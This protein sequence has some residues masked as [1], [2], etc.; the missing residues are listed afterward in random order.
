MPVHAAYVP[1]GGEQDYTNSSIDWGF[2]S[3]QRVESGESTYQLLRAG[4]CSG[5]SQDGL[6]R[7][8]P[9]KASNSSKVT[10]DV[11]AAP[12]NNLLNSSSLMEDLVSV[13]V[14][15]LVW[16]SPTLPPVL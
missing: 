16:S 5:D 7:T 15:I 14:D 11:E 6:P 8:V 13:G 9:C 3:P 2:S 4:V 10:A 1:E 12:Y